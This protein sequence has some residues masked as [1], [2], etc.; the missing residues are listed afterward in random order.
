MHLLALVL[1]AAPAPA[2]AAPPAPPAEVYPTTRGT[3]G[4]SFYLPGGGDSKGGI[5]E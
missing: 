4:V 2:V 5:Q 1:L 3:V